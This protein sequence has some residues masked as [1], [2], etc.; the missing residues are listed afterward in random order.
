MHC[1]SCKS[2][3]RTGSRKTSEDSFD[4]QIET[5]EKETIDLTIATDLLRTVI[6]KTVIIMDDIVQ[7]DLVLDNLMTKKYRLTYKRTSGMV[8]EI[9][10]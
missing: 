3:Q 2:R 5:T 10:E 8:L 4:I 7:D 1:Y 6:S 9:K